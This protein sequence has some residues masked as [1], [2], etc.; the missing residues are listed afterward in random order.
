MKKLP[1]LLLF[2]LSAFFVVPSV[3]YAATS[4]A[5]VFVFLNGNPTA[6]AQVSVT[7]N[8]TTVPATFVEINRYEATFADGVCDE[9]DTVTGTGTDPVSGAAGTGTGTMVDNEAFL[10]F[11]MVENVS[12]PEFGLLPGLFAGVSSLG[13]LLA[14][15]RLK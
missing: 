6:T 5:I 11:D 12:V 9:F 15:K 8:G 14:F 3:S 2:I 10:N 13:A 1:A 4:Q 7:C